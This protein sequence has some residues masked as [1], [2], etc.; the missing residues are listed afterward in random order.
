MVKPF[1]ARARIG[2]EPDPC[3]VRVE[4]LA[5]LVQEPP[6]QAVEGAGDRTTAL[7]ARVS[8]SGPGAGWEA[9]VPG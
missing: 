7:F 9:R 3:P 8:L 6:H 2:G 5:Q 1:A 4:P